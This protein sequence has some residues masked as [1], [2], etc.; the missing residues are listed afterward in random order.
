MEASTEHYLKIKSIYLELH[1]Q[2]MNILM[3]YGNF[4]QKA[5][6]YFVNN[7]RKMGVVSS[8]SFRSQTTHM[9]D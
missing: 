6:L 9:F 2:D 3:S 5:L 1:H 8:K 7:A 4:D